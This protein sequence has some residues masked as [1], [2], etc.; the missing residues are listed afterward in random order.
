M[1]RSARAGRRVR[2]GASPGIPNSAPP[3]P[4][5]AP[6]GPIVPKG[7]APTLSLGLGLTVWRVAPDRAAV[8]AVFSG[9]RNDARCA[10]ETQEGAGRARGARG[11]AARGA[12]R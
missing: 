8:P 6:C 7:G 11:G 5:L 12:G 9:H 4:Q 1:R 2:L 10:R 3:Q